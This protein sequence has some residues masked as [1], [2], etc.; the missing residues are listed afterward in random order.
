[1]IAMLLLVFVFL[2]VATVPVAFALGIASAAWIWLTKMV[3]FILIPQRMFA[4]IDSFP[5][6]AIP[7]FILAGRL[8]AE[9]G[10]SDRLIKVALS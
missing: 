9:G 2:I 8:M 5:L 6:I 1:M 4:G 7:F 10:S 3:P